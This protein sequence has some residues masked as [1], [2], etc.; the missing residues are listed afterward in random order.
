MFSCLLSTPMDYSLDEGGQWWLPGHD[1]RKVPGW[2]TFSEAE[3]GEL[4]LIGSLEGG[5]DDRSRWIAE[6]NADEGQYGRVLGDVSGV[7]VTLDGCMRV[8]RSANL[9]KNSL[10][11][12]RVR[13]GVVFKDVHYDHHE[14]AGG[15]RLDV[16][17][18]ELVYW[19]RPHA[20]EEPE[21][22]GDEPVFYRLNV[23]KLPNLRL[24]HETGHLLV[25]PRT[26]SGGGIASRRIDVAIEVANYAD[27]IEGW[28]ELHSP[29][30]VLR[31]LVSLLMS[32]HVGTHKATLFHPDREE[33]GTE[34]RSFRHQIELFV[35]WNEPAV[36][37][38][39]D[40]VPPFKHLVTFEDLGEDGLSSL[41]SV[42][43]RYASELRRVVATRS[44][45]AM[46]VS[47]RLL[48]RCSA[49]ESFDRQDHGD[50]RSFRERMKESADLAGDVFSTLVGDVD[51]WSKLLK[52]RR[53]DAAHQLISQSNNTNAGAVD[54]LLA[55]SVS[56][57]F[58]FCLL[59]R[60]DCAESVLERIRSQHAQY[61]WLQSN[62]K[63]LL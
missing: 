62:L 20:L 63:V 16:L 8:N 49:M 24:E 38:V 15:T 33:P 22:S 39:S 55:E 59:R 61:R 45:R 19:F 4:R 6:R 37:A 50:Q 43:Q 12:E 42:A 56:M 21:K 36:S 32:S 29:V 7:A 60:A 54:F 14:I 31:D 41:F 44:E 30:V 48:N 5:P 40:D 26:S 2:I 35:E 1:D 57:L 23:L 53:D 27:S 52:G 25:G 34:P 3:G 10:V 51:R 13:V 18:P 28:A 17:M 9:L 58:L 11:A 47:D 46:F